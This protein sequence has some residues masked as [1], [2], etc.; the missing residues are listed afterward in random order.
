MILLGLTM[1][2][3]TTAITSWALFAEA[4]RIRRT[5]ASRE[6]PHLLRVLAGEVNVETF[7]ARTW[8]RP[9]VIWPARRAVDRLFLDWPNLGAGVD[10]NA[11]VAEAYRLGLVGVVYEP[12]WVGGPVLMVGLK[13]EWRRPC[14]PPAPE[15]H[16]RRSRHCMG[17]CEHDAACPFTHGGLSGS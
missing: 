7:G 2:G 17:D 6:V 10:F 9:R 3:L 4:H 13:P 1:I 5:L 15:A 8:R 16:E 12:G 14:A 11:V